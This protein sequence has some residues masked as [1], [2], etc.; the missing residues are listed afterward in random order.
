[1][2]ALTLQFMMSGGAEFDEG[3]AGDAYLF[4]IDHKAGIIKHQGQ[5]EQQRNPH[6]FLHG[7][8]YTSKRDGRQLVFGTKE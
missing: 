4:L 2:D 6:Q 8:D 3:H 1:M 7:Q 5:E